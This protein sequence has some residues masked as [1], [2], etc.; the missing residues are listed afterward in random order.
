MPATQCDW[1]NV[2]PTI[3]GTLFE[4]TLDPAKRARIGAHYT[5]RMTSKR[6]SSPSC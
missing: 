3:F 6:C 2:E 5:S 4:R 1:L